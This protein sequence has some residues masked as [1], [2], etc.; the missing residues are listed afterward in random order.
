FI[1][2]IC[3]GSFAT[4]RP[5]PALTVRTE[6]LLWL[7]ALAAIPSALLMSSQERLIADQAFNS[8]EE[9][10]SVLKRHLERIDSGSSSVTQQFVQ[11]C[12]NILRSA[13][14]G[15]SIERAETDEA[16]GAR[17]LDSIESRCF[18]SGMELSGIF[19][20][21]HGGFRLTRVSPTMN[22]DTA[23][24]LCWYHE[25]LAGETLTRIAPQLAKEAAARP[26]KRSSAAEMSRLDILA[27]NDNFLGPA[28]AAYIYRLGN[29]YTLRYYD[30]VYQ[31]GGARYLVFILWTQDRV[32]KT[33]LSTALQRIRSESPA[34]G[35]CAFQPAASRLEMVSAAASP[36]QVGELSAAIRN[37]PESAAGLS[38]SV[39]YAGKA[40]PGYIFGATTSLE[41]LNAALSR[42]SH[43]SLALFFFMGF[44]LVG[45]GLLL[46]RW[47][48]DPVRRMSSALRRVAGDD[49]QAQVA[50]RRS[51]ELG[52]T[53][54]TLDTMIGW[55]RERRSMSRFVSSQVMD[56]VAKGR[57]GEQ[58][59]TGR[60]Q[61][62]LLVSDIRSFTTMSEAHPAPMIFSMLNA[63]LAAMTSIIQRHGGSIDRFI[64]D[65]IQA[66]FL[67]GLAAPPSER[68]V[69]AGGE[70]MEEHRR[71]QLQRSSRGEFT[72]GIGIGIDQGEVVTG[73][74]GDP[75]VRL[76]FT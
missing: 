27:R 6:L 40:M 65:A 61:A 59:Q 55:L 16:A 21:G 74:L 35:I 33:Y 58:A 26:R 62:T 67:P 36:G 34:L 50:I 24:R 18:S 45:A 19:I 4:G 9:L 8:R 47:L 56:V 25:V 71:L 32:Y 20:Y 31:R 30:L 43:R 54:G 2:F 75:Q 69:R 5:V 41:P 52:D 10:R 60:T 1:I 22:P 46:S 38:E 72:Y 7:F 64:G 12:R 70:M 39:L 28:D 73:I 66:V 42:D 68:A 76:D 3:I 63:H 14:L 17:L 51:D 23:D 37:L 53:A 29:K 11:E 57:L 48:A 15:P 13:D 49:L 44:L